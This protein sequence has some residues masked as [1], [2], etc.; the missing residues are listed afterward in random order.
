MAA[1]SFQLIRLAASP[2]LEIPA[3]DV[4]KPFGGNFE[5][6]D[7]LLEDRHLAPVLFAIGC[8]YFEQ[9]Q[10]EFVFLLHRQPIIQFIE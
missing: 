9:Y 1:D 3:I 5:S 7:G 4:V 2:A 10:H 8:D 6:G